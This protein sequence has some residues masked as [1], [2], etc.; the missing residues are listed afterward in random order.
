[1]RALRKGLPPGIMEDTRMIHF[2][3]ALPLLMPSA[4]PP[5]EPLAVSV[6]QSPWQTLAT[7]PSTWIHDISF[8]SALVG[9]AVGESGQVFKTEDGAKSWTP[10]L[11]AP[12]YLTGVHALNKNDVV[13]T[14]F[15]ASPTDQRALIRWSHDGGQTWSDTLTINPTYNPTNRIHFWDSNTGVAMSFGEPNYAFR[16]TTGGL[17]LTDWS[18]AEVDPNGGWFG[19]QFSALPNGHMRISGITYCESLDY[20]ATFNCRPSIDPGSDS[21]TFFLDDKRGWVGGGSSSLPT[22][23]YIHR[24]LDGGQT[25][26]DRVLEGPWMIREILFVNK[27]DGWAAGGA[28]NVGGVYVSHDGGENWAVELDTRVGLTSCATAD[29]HLYCA[30]F[31]DN[32]TSHFYA[33][34]YD[35][36][37]GN[38]F[39]P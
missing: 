27:S 16:T 28:G 31:D 13:I 4:L 25:W 21:A 29:Y 8:V 38:A 35:K 33:R 15:T 1:M 7:L 32:G 10:V 36:I 14:G 20:A 9:Y 2:L 24:T 5:H 19:A 17:A 22:T 23:G 3:A 11:N 30:G 39:D 6:Q 34:D 12:F 26:S 18:R 37:R